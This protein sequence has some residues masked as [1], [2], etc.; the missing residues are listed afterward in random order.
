EKIEMI[1]RH[2]N[3]LIDL[4]GEKIGI[5]EMRKHISWYIK[6]FKN[7][8]VIRQEIFKMMSKYDIVELLKACKPK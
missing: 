3:M 1:I 4:K 8:A 2:M 7:A 6:G 5:L